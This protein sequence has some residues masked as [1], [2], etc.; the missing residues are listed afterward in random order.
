[1]GQ[2][3]FT[4]IRTAVERHGTAHQRACAPLERG[5][6]GEEGEE[7]RRRSHRA[8]RMG[9][10]CSGRACRLGWP[11]LARAGYVRQSG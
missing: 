8:W 5:R 7:R 9:A 6:R 4:K 11:G 10:E 2:N 1:M 3:K